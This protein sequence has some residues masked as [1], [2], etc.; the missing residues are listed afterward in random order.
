MFNTD[1]MTEVASTLKLD[2]AQFKSCLQQTKYADK[3]SKDM[4]DGEATG[5]SGTPTFIVGKSTSGATLNGT[6][7]VGAQTI[8][9]FKKVIDPLLAQ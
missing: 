3:I 9:S 2:T 6:A 4:S 5:V 1:K 7:L 8:S